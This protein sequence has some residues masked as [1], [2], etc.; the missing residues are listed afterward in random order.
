MVSLGGYRV[1]E[2]MLSLGGYIRILPCAA[3]PVLFMVCDV[4]D[5]PPLPVYCSVAQ[6]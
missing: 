2:D 4:R 3:A 1:G 6:I 5:I